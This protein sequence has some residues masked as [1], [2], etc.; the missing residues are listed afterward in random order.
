MFNKFIKKN[1]LRRNPPA[2]D[3]TVDVSNQGEHRTRTGLK[4]VPSSR[5]PMNAKK[6]VRKVAHA[7]NL[8]EE[9]KLKYFVLNVMKNYEIVLIRKVA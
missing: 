3:N 1:P 4:F 6:P 2:W 7:R 9:G 5:G 8:V